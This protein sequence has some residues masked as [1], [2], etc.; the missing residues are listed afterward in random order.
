MASFIGPMTAHMPG[1]DVETAAKICDRSFELYL[2]KADAETIQDTKNR[3]QLLGCIRIIDYMDR[4]KGLPERERVINFCA[5][6]MER[7]LQIIP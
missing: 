2:D 1:I 3:A 6:D 7:I 5:R 4:H